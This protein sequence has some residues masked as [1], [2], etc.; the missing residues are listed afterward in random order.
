MGNIFEWGLGLREHVPPNASSPPPPIRLQGTCC[1]G[2]LDQSGTCCASGFVDECGVCDGDSTSCSL[3]LSLELGFGATEAAGTKNSINGSGDDA[4]AWELA[5][6]E[7]LT[8][9]A[10]AAGL[11]SSI[12]RLAYA[13][14]LNQ[15]PVLPTTTMSVFALL[16]FNSMEAASGSF[17]YT[18][19]GLAPLLSASLAAPLT[20]PLPLGG[21]SSSAASISDVIA[22]SVRIL[23]V[24]RAGICGNGVCEVGEQ[25]WEEP[26][27]PASAQVS[28]DLHFLQPQ[29]CSVNILTCLIYFCRDT[30]GY[31][32]I[33]RV[34]TLI[35]T[36]RPPARQTAP[37]P[38]VAAPPPRHPVWA[39]PPWSA[40][41]M[42]PA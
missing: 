7:R 11:P 23:M 36:C 3:A 5:L 2:P 34:P 28:G 14:G 33:S 20:L 40:E 31:N 39:I 41:V 18:V 37:S 16:T 19:S 26:W 24:D 13:S 42:G 17:R 38:S 21:S 32:S 30:Q 35:H 1:P 6:M 29:P 8:S 10:E 27:A 15:S 25:T 22:P 9:A 12:S 4:A